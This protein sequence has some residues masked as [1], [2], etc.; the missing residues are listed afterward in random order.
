VGEPLTATRTF[1]NVVNGHLRY[2][3]TSSDVG[4]NVVGMS[5]D[6]LRELLALIASDTK[7]VRYAAVERLRAALPAIREAMLAAM[8]SPDWKVRASAAAVLD[9][10][11]QD[12]A[13]EQALRAASRDTDARVRDSAFHSL[14]CGHCKPDGCLADDA[15]DLLVDGMLHDPSVRVRRKLAGGMMW[16]QQGRRPP[17]VEAFREIL[18]TDTDLVLRDRAATFL[19]TGDVPRHGSHYREW[20]PAFTLRKAELL[21][22]S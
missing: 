22:T 2:R 14:S 1:P 21:T 16:G 11:E 19:A 4:H 20:L 17:I 15:V 13:V 12:A 10:A 9:H 3:S 7:A 18:T 5:D 8:T 6:E